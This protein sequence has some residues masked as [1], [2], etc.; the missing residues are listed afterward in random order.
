MTTIPISQ[1]VREAMQDALHIMVFTG[2]G[3]SAESGIPTFRD[4]LDGLWARFNPA[5]LATPEAFDANPAL[6]WHWYEARRH[7]VL[8]ARPNP[9][10]HAIAALAGKVPRLTLVTQNVDDLHERA[11]STD[12]IHLHGSLHA[13]RCRRCQ[14]AWQA[15]STPD[16]STPD[17]QETLEAPVDQASELPDPPRCPDCSDFIR[18]GV[19][20]FGEMLP[21]DGLAQALAAAQDCDVLISVGTSGMVWPAAQLPWQ[22]FEQGA[23][24]VQVNPHPTELDPVAHANLHGAAGEW[25]PQLLALRNED[26]P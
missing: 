19:V 14:R 25:L 13:P 21:E 3:V 8:E 16:R 22:A 5:E 26:A 10:H 11:G 9:A 4:A 23:C 2:A 1:E 6:V 20:W 7:K 15:P 12:V 17:H 18:P 24:I